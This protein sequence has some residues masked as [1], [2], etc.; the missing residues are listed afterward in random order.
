MW[1]IFLKAGHHS[2]LGSIK[3]Q[4]AKVVTFI[5]DLLD[6]CSFALQL[7]NIHTQAG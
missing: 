4:Q 6:I 2:G 3:N 1:S 5:R 7:P